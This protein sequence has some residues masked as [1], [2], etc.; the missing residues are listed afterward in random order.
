M[1]KILIVDNSI[2]IR[3]ILKNSFLDNQEVIIFEADSFKE[4]C[5]LVVEH[6]FFIVVSNLVLLDSTNSE[7]LK[8]L[9]KE[10][11]PTIIFSSNLE[12]DS[13]D[14]EYSN[15]INHVIKNANGF[16]FIYKL[17]SAMIYCN[18]EE[19]LVID[20]STTQA[21]YIKEVLEKL[22]VK[23]SIVKNGIKALSL[24]EKNKNI[25]LIL[26]DYEMPI[27]DE[28]EF[29]KK[30]RV[31][32]YYNQIPIIIV[33]NIYDIYLKKQFYKYG[34]NDILI[35]P[36]LEEELISKVTDIFLNLKHIEEIVSFNQLVNK[37]VISSSTD[38]YGKIL[39]VSDAF[40]KISG[41]KRDELIGK[42]HKKGDE[43][44]I[45]F[46][47]CLK[48]SLH[49]FTDFVFRLGGEEFAVVF[50]AENKEK[51]IKF[52]E[53]IRKNIENMKIEH[54]YNISTPYITTSMG[55]IC[56]YAKD[57]DYND[58]YK[59]ADDLLYQAKENGRNQIKVNN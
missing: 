17:V 48:D 36:I 13:L 27:M 31:H 15:I 19:I 2:V 33:T 35:K 58:I 24:L 12:A 16:K 59:E 42:N 54:K 8:L 28:L 7:L 30:I 18:N 47:K 39:S 23:V 41:Y 55:L 46:A 51:A 37:S 44:L 34:A 32:K 38:I 3:N 49:R 6:T 57:I 22:L 21:N 53:K 50:Q 14:I 29:T 56:K 43:V 10:N 25:S 1:K 20:D 40:C 26:S 5:K 45:N 11:I 52:A 9:K 4:V